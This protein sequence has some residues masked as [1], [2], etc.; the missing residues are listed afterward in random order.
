MFLQLNLS[1]FDSFVIFCAFR[2]SNCLACFQAHA[3]NSLTRYVCRSVGLS[4]CQSPFAFMAFLAFFGVLHYSSCQNACIGLL[5]LPLPTHTRFWQP[6]IQPCQMRPRIS[7]IGCV[8]LSVGLL[9]CWLVGRV[10]HS[11]KSQNPRLFHQKSSIDKF[12]HSFIHSFI[13]LFIHS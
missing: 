3:H 4:V 2:A 5:S 7:I 13:Y 8:R 12:T 6:C 10:T 1:F 9:V 11:S